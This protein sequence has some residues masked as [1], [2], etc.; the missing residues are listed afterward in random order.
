ME[1]L[2]GFESGINVLEG[3]GEN[4]MNAGPAIG[5]WRAFIKRVQRSVAR[6]RQLFLKDLVCPPEFENPFF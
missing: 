2:H 4:V 6:L 3:A 1:P 5:R